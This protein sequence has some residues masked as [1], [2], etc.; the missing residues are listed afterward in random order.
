[1]ATTIACS[2]D[3]CLKPGIGNWLLNK[4]LK[5]TFFWGKKYFFLKFH[6]IFHY[7]NFIKSLIFKI[8]FSA[9]FAL[10]WHFP[11]RYGVSSS[12][13]P[14]YLLCSNLNQNF[15]KSFCQNVPWGYPVLWEAT[16]GCGEEIF[17]LCAAVCLQI[18]FRDLAAYLLKIQICNACPDVCHDLPVIPDYWHF[19]LSQLFVDLQSQM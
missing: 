12:I 18:T 7:K 3:E 6:Y 14:N 17:I 16:L 4:L 10:C 11:G 13:C 19:F 8:F 1:M 15:L 2:A 9:C 5:Q